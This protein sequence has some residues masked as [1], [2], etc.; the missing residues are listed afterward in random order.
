MARHSLTSMRRAS[1]C[2]VIYRPGERLRVPCCGKSETP[3]LSTSPNFQNRVIA[4]VSTV[5][6][7]S[8]TSCFTYYPRDQGLPRPRLY[9]LFLRF[10]SFPLCQSPNL[11]RY[12][13]RKSVNLSLDLHY[14]HLSSPNL[15]PY[16]PNASS[17]PP[18]LNT[19][20][21]DVHTVHAPCHALKHTKTA[22]HALASVTQL[23]SS[24]SKV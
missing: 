16:R 9:R 23:L 10:L 20:V 22:S 3:P 17:A 18:R 24:L 19:P 14:F 6:Y 13:R 15:A 2:I 5:S 12:R 1:Y 8:S 4:Q 11:P 21:H 7:L